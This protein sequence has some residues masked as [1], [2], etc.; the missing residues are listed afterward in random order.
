[1]FRQLG[2][3]RI[4]E[5]IGRGGMGTVYSGVHET[6]GERAAIKVLSS[7]SA[8]ETNFRDRFKLEIETL[9]QLKHP[10][11]VQLLGEGVQDGQLFFV[12]EL[13]DGRSLQDELQAGRRFTWQE[14]VNI[15]IQI[16][17]ALKHAHDHGV[18][19]RDLKP[20]N[21]LRTADGQIK[22]TDFGIAKLFGSTQLTADGSVVGTAD[23]MAPEQA[24]RRPTTPRTDLFSLGTVMFA[25]LARRPPFAGDSLP[26]VVHKLCFEKPPPVRRF[27]PTV[28][29]ELE[30]IIE[31]LLRKD[32]RERIATALALA[33]RLRALEHATKLTSGGGPDRPDPA[34]QESALSK[35][36]D[37]D[38]PTRVLPLG[39]GPR[40][41][42]PPTV[43]NA[44]SVQPRSIPAGG[45]AWNDAT[46]VTPERPPTEVGT[47]SA[48]AA[49]GGA[50]AAGEAGE[51]APEPPSDHFVT[52]D[53]ATSTSATKRRATL[54]ARLEVIGVAVA[55]VALVAAIVTYL[56]PPNADRLYS[57]ILRSK[58][59]PVAVTTQIDDF[60]D[61]FPKDPR[62]P[63]IQALSRDV[64][65]TQAKNQ[66]R[67]IRAATLHTRAEQLFLEGM[68]LKEDGRLTEAREVFQRLIDEVDPPTPLG[69]DERDYRA[70]ARHQLERIAAGGSN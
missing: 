42:I 29:V 8:D 32:P 56:R 46:A 14:V 62:W 10:H 11:I 33:N 27:A 45:F 60:L 2:P 52:V 13:V 24:E 5:R 39:N 40:T 55:L 35:P 58:N 51:V 57:R 48:G 12:M 15:T 4:E 22:L 36:V 3:Y 70:L 17:Q 66:L 64:A 59:E 20:A 37:H 21:L 28:P 67:F 7:T 63:E 44:G 50:S 68:L 30:Q 31:Q 61:R 69:A 9:K 49:T 18:I 16:C 23:F 38:Q 34:K 54:W 6:T 65:S 19:H 43:A 53:S 25:L 41:E 47:S 26:Q 1:M